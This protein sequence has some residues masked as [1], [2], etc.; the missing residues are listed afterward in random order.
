MPHGDYTDEQHAQME[1]AEEIK[2]LTKVLKAKAMSTVVHPPDVKVSVGTPSI[3]IPAPQIIIKDEAYD[4]EFS[5]HKDQH[6]R[7]IGATARV[8]RE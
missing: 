3:S 2:A 1:L 7:L 6:G 5:F 8:I 4:Y